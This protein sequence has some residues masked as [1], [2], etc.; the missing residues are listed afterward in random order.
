MFYFERGLYLQKNKKTVDYTA[1][2]A[3]VKRGQQGDKTAVEALLMAFK[4]ML[5]SVVSRYVYNREELEDAYQAVSYTH[6][7]VYKRQV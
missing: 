3:L 7:D 4:P 2:D 1:L 5:W 6:L